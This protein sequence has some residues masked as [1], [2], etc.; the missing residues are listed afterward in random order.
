ME[1]K[2]SHERKK[3]VYDKEK[4]RNYEPEDEEDD[5]IDELD[6]EELKTDYI[7]IENPY[8]E[9]KK[10]YLSIVTSIT[11]FRTLGYNEQEKKIEITMKSNRPSTVII[12]NKMV[13]INK[14]ITKTLN[15][16]LRLMSNRKDDRQINMYKGSS[17]KQVTPV[18]LVKIAEFFDK[19][20]GTNVTENI[21]IKPNNTK[22]IIP[23]KITPSA[24]S[25]F[26][27]SLVHLYS[28]DTEQKDYNRRPIFKQFDEVF[29]LDDIDLILSFGITIGK[30][31]L[32]KIP[33]KVSNDKIYNIIEDIYKD[34]NKYKYYFDLL[35][36]FD[37]NDYKYRL[38]I[39]LFIDSYHDFSKKA[40]GGKD[41]TLQTEI[42]KILR[43]PEKSTIMNYYTN[44]VFDENNFRQRGY[45]FE[46]ETILNN[47][48]D[49][50]TVNKRIEIFK[51]LKEFVGKIIGQAF[52][53]TFLYL[54]MYYIYI[55]KRFDGYNISRKISDFKANYTFNVQGTEKQKINVKRYTQDFLMRNESYR[56]GNTPKHFAVDDKSKYVYIPA[57]LMDANKATS[58]KNPKDYTKEEPIVQYDIGKLKLL[59]LFNDDGCNL[60]V[61]GTEGDNFNPTFQLYAEQSC[62][63]QK[64]P[65]EFDEGLDEYER[66]NTNTIAKKNLYNLQDNLKDIENTLKNRFNVKDI[67][68]LST[69]FIKFS[70]GSDGI[71]RGDVLSLILAFSD[72]L[73]KLNKPIPIGLIDRL[74][75]LKRLGDF[76]QI[77]N[78]KKLDIPLF[79]QDSMEN[80]LAIVNCTKTIF[81][82][83][84]TYI[85]Y[86]GT[87]INSNNN[88]VNNLLDPTSSCIPTP[89]FIQKQQIYRNFEPEYND[90][91]ITEFKQ[92]KQLATDVLNTKRF[93]TQIAQWLKNRFLQLFVNNIISKQCINGINKEVIKLNHCSDID[94]NIILKVLTNY[95]NFLIKID[96]VSQTQKLDDFILY[97][98]MKYDLYDLINNFTSGYTNKTK[99]ATSILL[100]TVF[101][102]LLYDINN[103]CEL[104][105]ISGCKNLEDYLTD[106]QKELKQQLNHRIQ[107]DDELKH[108]VN[109]I[110][111]NENLYYKNTY[112]Q[113]QRDLI[114]DKKKELDI[115]ISELKRK[116]KNITIMTD[117]IKLYRKKNSRD[118]VRKQLKKRSY[119]R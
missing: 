83:N 96:T 44:V 80:L 106:Y 3:R 113:F 48:N 15:T 92:Y 86:N 73:T 101:N 20:M 31:Y 102:Q 81:G 57:A 41:K 108:E 13:D 27:N 69:N 40:T 14:L 39:L 67:K 26:Y 2:Y 50:D 72:K 65:I 11:N 70:N 53:K 7:A 64:I 60:S 97:L 1:R 12:D 22:N 112:A 90:N 32:F 111:N 115:D 34:K 18:L 100:E 35:N 105:N 17:S 119:K 30:K 6:I 43:L 63:G 52:E 25:N 95:L 62:K 98:F 103:I 51:I 118:N 38:P 19:N 109:T 59:Y 37:R 5:D 116:D 55:D 79:T 74:L 89:T 42:N 36:W 29:S 47:L 45:E 4:Y 68:N 110:Y 56:V 46:Y 104:N 94:K 33:T 85:Y 88:T 82:N 10:D 9:F 78:C 21:L 99:Y 117:S 58:S 71:S 77:E 28:V 107:Y 49:L 84:P 54:Y 66:K 93:N 61:V 8:I 23:M 87:G 24:V 91:I 76:G 75:S 114:K 16:K